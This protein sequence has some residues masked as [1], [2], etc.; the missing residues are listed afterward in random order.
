MNLRY[1]PPFSRAWELLARARR[2]AAPAQAARVEELGGDVD[3]LC[4]Q[5]AAVKI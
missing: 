2:A 4:G 1:R 5:L 3:E